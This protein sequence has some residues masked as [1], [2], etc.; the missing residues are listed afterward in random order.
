[1]QMCAPPTSDFKPCGRS[2]QQARQCWKKQSI[3]PTVAASGVLP[4]ATEVRKNTSQNYF[5]KDNDRNLKQNFTLFLSRFY[6]FI[7]RDR[8]RG[9]ET[10]KC[11]GHSRTPYWGP[12]PQPRHVPQLG[13]EP[14]IFWF[15]G[16]C[17]TTEPHQPGR[18]LSEYKHTHL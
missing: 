7:F 4:I 5:S 3:P 16:W 10:S 15:A 13:L 17:S 9:R 8:E 18:F 6:L 1:M 12:G 11:H 2:C 14:A